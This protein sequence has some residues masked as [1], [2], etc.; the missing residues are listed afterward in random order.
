MSGHEPR[1]GHSITELLRLRR[2]RDAVGHPYRQPIGPWLYDGAGNWRPG[3]LGV[4]V[5]NALGSH[6]VTRGPGR[7]RALVTSGL[8]AE[9]VPRAG[10]GRGPLDMHA[11][12]L[13]LDADGGTAHGELRNADGEPLALATVSGRF[14][15]RTGETDR[16][17]DAVSTAPVLSL[18]DIV[19]AAP[20]VTRDGARLTIEPGPWLANAR[21]GLHGGVSTALAE[22]AAAAALGEG[23]WRTSSLRVDFM[24]ATPSG[25]TLRADATVLRRGRSVAFVRATLGY[26][27]SGPLT[28]ALLTYL[29]G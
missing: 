12:V 11:A 18:T 4:Y 29:A 19:G 21:G 22:Y 17:G 6:L 14:I 9:F 2:H 13:H 25:R 16:P 3:A 26:E 27:D 15:D 10:P 28:I 23:G 7:S 5:D 1:S 8:T 20:V 24:R